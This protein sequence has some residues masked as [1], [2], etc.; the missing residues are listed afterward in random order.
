MCRINLEFAYSG[1]L[2]ERLILLETRVGEQFNVLKA[3]VL[4]LET[5]LRD[6]DLQVK[7]QHRLLHQ[8][9]VGNKRKR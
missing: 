7:R 9:I 1:E 2:D 3:M 6:Q 8:A 5:K 4:D